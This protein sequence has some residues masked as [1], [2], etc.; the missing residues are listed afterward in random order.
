MLRIEAP[1]GADDVSD[2]FRRFVK[3]GAPSGEDGGDVQ[4]WGSMAINDGEGAF[5]D[6]VINHGKR[7][8]IGL[9]G[10]L[11]RLR[12]V[13][14]GNLRRHKPA[15]EPRHP[16]DAVRCG[17][18]S[19][20]LTV[21]QLEVSSSAPAWVSSRAASDSSEQV[22]VLGVTVPVCADLPVRPDRAMPKS[23]SLTRSELVSRKF[24]GLMSL[25]MTRLGRREW[26]YSIALPMSTLNERHIL[27]PGRS[28]MT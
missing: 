5:P 2:R 16:R 8:D 28:F 14:R 4:G 12:S 24:A 18:K 27:G 7:V 1:H 22:D 26:R 13:S 10:I 25:W 19:S 23:P 3:V 6:E 17:T 11:S 15:D 9:G 20:Y 21:P